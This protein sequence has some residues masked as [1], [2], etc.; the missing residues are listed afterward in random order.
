MV[1]RLEIRRETFQQDVLQ[2]HLA[3]ES[4]RIEII[5]AQNQLAA[6]Q[7]GTVRV[8]SEH[9]L[10]VAQEPRVQFGPRERAPLDRDAARKEIQH[11][12]EGNSRFCLP[13][14]WEVGVLRPR[15]DVLIDLA[16]VLESAAGFLH[17]VVHASIDVH[18]HLHEKFLAAQTRIRLQH[19]LVRG[20]A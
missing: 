14:N 13:E 20:T 7:T 17:V 2:T 5:L 6:L 12:V 1:Q 18:K 3:Q 15:Q 9:V 10:Q 4:V 19:P 8:V 11:V 16:L